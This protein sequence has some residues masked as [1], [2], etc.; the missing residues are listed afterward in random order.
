MATRRNY[1]GVR[2]V[3][4]AASGSSTVSVRYGREAEIILGFGNGSYRTK[5]VICRWKVTGN[6]RREAVV[7]FVRT[8][9]QA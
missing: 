6:F 2:C 7:H 1:L 8:I 4:K 3:P 9:V 5:S